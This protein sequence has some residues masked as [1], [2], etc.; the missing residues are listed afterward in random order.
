LRHVRPIACRMAQFLAISCS[1][2][3]IQRTALR[4]KPVASTSPTRIPHARPPATEALTTGAF[5]ARRA[6][7]T[8]SAVKSRPLVSV[9]AIFRDSAACRRARSVGWTTI[10]REAR[11]AAVVRA[12]QMADTRSSSANNMKHY[13]YESIRVR[14]LGL[15]LL[16]A[17]C[18]NEPPQPCHP[19]SDSGIVSVACGDQ[20]RAQR[21]SVAR[22]RTIILLHPTGFSMDAV[23]LLLNNARRVLAPTEGFSTTKHT[24]ATRPAIAPP[25]PCAA[26]ISWLISQAVGLIVSG[27]LPILRVSRASKTASALMGPPSVVQPVRMLATAV[28]LQACTATAPAMRAA[29]AHVFQAILVALSTFVGRFRASR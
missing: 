9:T 13:L 18:S 4:E 16:T 10:P 23:W 19:A 11:C 3:M 7:R 12:V 21:Q 27:P 15:M 25:G 26:R 14:F 29:P 6:K 5:K 24:C 8:V 22:R 17:S 20:I 2:V 1:N 28:T